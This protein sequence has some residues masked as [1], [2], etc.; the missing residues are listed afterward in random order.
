MR[1]FKELREEAIGLYNQGWRASDKEQLR[2]VCGYRGEELKLIVDFL[3]DIA[4][5]YSDEWGCC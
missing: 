5:S 1:P 2:Q 3:G 4:L